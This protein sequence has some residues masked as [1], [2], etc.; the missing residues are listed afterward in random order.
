VS[1]TASTFAATSVDVCIC[2]YR[3]PEIVKTIGS[4]AGQTNVGGVGVR[5]VV[6]DNTADGAARTRIETSCRE[7]GLDFTYVH[8]PA[9]NISIARN[10][11]LDAATAD[12]IAFL[13]DDEVVVPTWLSEL[14]A[15][16]ARGSWDAV[17]GPVHGVYPP[18]VP[19]WM[20]EGGFHTTQPVWVGTRILTGYT[21]NVLF[22]RSLSEALGL[23]FNLALGKSGGEDGDFFY[24]FTD[25]GGRIGFAPGAS[26]SEPVPIARATIQWL[27]RRNFRAGQSHGLRLRARRKPY[28]DVPVAS[29][30]AALCGAGALLNLANPARRN[31]FLTRAAL[32][33]GVVARL[34]GLQE[35]Q[36]Y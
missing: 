28:V 14:L 16:A 35:V 24:R 7:L 5:I 2:S 17:L 33:C 21:G 34:S 9:N 20:A 4:V 29:V 23:R 3:R 12:W 32:H 11:C 27:L 36:M 25:G 6:A 13:D 31:R 19:G 15:E 22:R 30:K 18:E 1:Q 26:A 8:A 10:A